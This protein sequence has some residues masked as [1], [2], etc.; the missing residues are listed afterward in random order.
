[1]KPITPRKS[2]GY[3]TAADILAN[4]LVSDDP[5][6]MQLDRLPQDAL[7]QALKSRLL[8]QRIVSVRWVTGEFLIMPCK[9]GTDMPDPAMV[10]AG[11]RTLHTGL[12]D[13]S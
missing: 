13:T 5:N 8:G 6:I 11:Y 10:V 12:N 1:M 2:A 3:T 7:D 9:P 4:A